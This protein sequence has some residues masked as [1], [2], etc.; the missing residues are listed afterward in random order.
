MEQFRGKV[1][2]ITGAASGIGR[3]T[4]L[5]FA[6]RGARLAVCD[7][8][9][10][11]LKRLA[12]ELETTGCELFTEVVDVSQAWQ[13][14]EFA[15]NVFEMMG[16][17]DILV[18]NAGVGVGAR[19][20]DMSLEDWKW[21]LGANLW[22]V[23]NCCHF[24]YPRMIRQGFGQIVNISSGAALSPLP[25]MIAYNTSKAGVLSFSETLRAEA[26]GYGIGV[27]V[28]CPGLIATDIV[29]KAR[30]MVCT[31]R[32]A[33]EEFK[34]KVDWVFQTRNYAPS[35]VAE[36]LIRGVSRNKGVIVVGPETYLIDIAHR[37][38]RSLVGLAL[39][40]MSALTSKM[41]T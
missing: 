1:V 36:K 23:I 11:G 31:R 37:V 19:M 29:R 18:N 38:S 15:E 21:L 35:R 27:S 12:G 40:L 17:T 28:V 10:E 22:G 7:I 24:F 20:E 2:V 4:A 33:A 8:D 34:E 26:A 5:A 39:R 16:R 13:V 6:R 3:E 9:G 25:L 32:L 14:E 41:E 30:V